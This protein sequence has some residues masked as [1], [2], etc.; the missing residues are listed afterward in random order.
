MSSWKE[1]QSPLTEESFAC[2]YLQSKCP[3]LVLAEE[4]HDLT[5]VLVCGL[6]EFRGQI[7]PTCGI[8]QSSIASDLRWRIP[9]WE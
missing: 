3:C 2:I 9:E 7:C 8:S 6:Q 1:G 5:P 4:L